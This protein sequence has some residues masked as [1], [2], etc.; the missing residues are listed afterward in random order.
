MASILPVL[1]LSLFLQCTPSYSQQAICMLE[2]ATDK[3]SF[4]FTISPA[5]YKPNT[6]Y[7]V[8]VSGLQ[9]EVKVALSASMN[10]S[11]IGTWENN[12]SNCSG[13][14]KE[15]SSNLEARWTSS[16][17]NYAYVEFRA[18]AMMDNKTYFQTKMINSSDTMTN[19]TTMNSTST[20]PMTSH[21]SDIMT[22][23]T[24]MNS[25]S[26][27]PMTSHAS[28]I[29]TNMTTM[30]STSTTPMTSH[31]KSKM[32]SPMTH[33][34]NNMTTQTTTAMKTT[35]SNTAGMVIGF[36]TLHA[37]TCML[38]LLVTAP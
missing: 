6:T 18:Y 33:M 8:T 15:T 35:T 25:T 19:M 7:N 17:E 31:D 14:L 38:L 34:T 37:F 5:V 12:T 28:D 30:N 27:T 9:N 2:N 3:E 11:I 4:T 16:S 20:T 26:T 21:A 22:N 24:T 36:K 23:M 1:L 13:I 32:T 10:N 29:M